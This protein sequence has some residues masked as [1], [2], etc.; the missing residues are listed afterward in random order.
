[1]CSRRRP[2]SLACPAI[3]SISR[4]WGPILGGSRTS[5]MRSTT[6]PT[7]ASA[8]RSIRSTRRIPR[9]MTRAP[10]VDCWLERSRGATALSDWSTTGCCA[11]CSSTGCGMRCAAVCHTVSPVRNIGRRVSARPRSQLSK[12]YRISNRHR[13][14][15]T[16]RTGPFRRLFDR[17]G[18]STSVFCRSWATPV[19]GPRVSPTT[20]IT[21]R[22]RGSPPYASAMTVVTATNVVIVVTAVTV[23]IAVTAAA[24]I[25]AMG[26]GQHQRPLG[27]A[28][29]EAVDDLIGSLLRIVTGTERDE[30][31]REV[32]DRGV[33]VRHSR[34]RPSEI[35]Q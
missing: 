12:R 7:T 4:R 5:S 19:A 26:S 1:M 30:Q 32:L 9:S 3:A 35:D 22:T 16:R 21:A 24:V 23:V 6:S 33:R 13:R 29:P 25:D 14:R 2:T 34:G 20:G 28:H 17:I 11:S 10:N 31:W 27:Q 15:T 18:R 8:G